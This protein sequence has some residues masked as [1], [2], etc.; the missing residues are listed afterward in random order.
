MLNV[1]PPDHTRLRQ[2]VPGPSP[3]ADRRAR[4]RHPARSPTTFSTSWR[5]R[6]P[7]ATVDLVEGFAY[8]LP[9]QVIGELLG[10]PRA[11]RP[12]STR[13]SRFC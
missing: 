3:V 1:D 11:D 12:R 10:I 13:G 8:P 4:A 7:T 2:L 9:F 6:V 5:R